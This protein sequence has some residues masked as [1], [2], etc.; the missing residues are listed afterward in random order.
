MAYGNLLKGRRS[1]VGQEYLVTT[2]CKRRMPVF[3]KKQN[4]E[5]LINEFA[6]EEAAD[7]AT[8]IAWVVMPD[9][10]HGLLSLG[11]NGDLSDLMRRIN[12]RTS[13]ALGGHP[14]QGGFHDHA[15]R[16]DESRL[17]VARYLVSNPVRAGLVESLREYPFWYCRW[18][19]EGD[20]PDC[21]LV[22]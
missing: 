22:R 14:W 5:R 3:S 11:C 19:R 1:I 6:R 9:H 15:L 13:R 21:L 8:W 4:A 10:W 20:D 16:S 7:S 18:H 12:G 17:S 2:A